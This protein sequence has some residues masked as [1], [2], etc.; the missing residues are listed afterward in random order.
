MAKSVVL[1]AK[2]KPVLVALCRILNDSF[3][4]EDGRKSDKESSSIMMRR[5]FEEVELRFYGCLGL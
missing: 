4:L 2:A 3:L 5:S 1:L